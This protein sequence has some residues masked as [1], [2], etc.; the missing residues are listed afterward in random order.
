MAVMMA[1]E[2]RRLYKWLYIVAK[3]YTQM[4]NGDYIALVTF[5]MA[6]IVAIPHR[7]LIVAIEHRRLNK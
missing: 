4:A 6:V 5:K 1:I 7:W 3:L 2:H